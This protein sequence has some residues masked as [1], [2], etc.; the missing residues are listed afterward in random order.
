[1]KR[2]HRL[3]ELY[4]RPFFIKAAFINFEERANAEE[5]ADFNEYKEITRAL[6]DEARELPLLTKVAFIRRTN[7][8]HFGTLYEHAQPHGYMAKVVNTK[9]ELV[10]SVLIQ[11]MEKVD[12]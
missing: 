3:L 7:E 8:I 5:K 2:L 11:T 4:R 12:D 1:M 10:E 9:T 6:C